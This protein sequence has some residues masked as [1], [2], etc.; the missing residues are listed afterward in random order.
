MAKVF[1][2]SEK[3]YFG[4]H[5]LEMWY[6]AECRAVHLRTADIV[7]AFDWQEFARFINAIVDIYC[8]EGWQMIQSALP[9][10]D[11]NNIVLN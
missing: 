10:D 6:C 4:E 11:E 8:N 2:G 9:N 5:Q 3:R 7:I 1:I